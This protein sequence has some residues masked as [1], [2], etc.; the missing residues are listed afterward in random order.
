MTGRRAMPGQAGPGAVVC[1]Y[2]HR[3]IAERW[4]GTPAAAVTGIRPV[5][6][7]MISRYDTY[8]RCYGATAASVGQLLLLPPALEELLFLTGFHRWNILQLNV[9]KKAW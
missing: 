8:R 3:I 2:V 4:H 6:G 5:C 1:M 9:I 7:E